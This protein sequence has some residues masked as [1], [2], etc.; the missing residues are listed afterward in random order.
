MNAPYDSAFLHPPLSFSKI[1]YPLSGIFD[2]SVGTSD[3]LTMNPVGMFSL[4]N[5][6]RKA[7][8]STKVFNVAKVFLSERAD[9]TVDTWQYVRN[10]DARIYGI[11]L[12]WSAH[13]A[14]AFELARRLK[15]ERPESVILFGGLTSTRYYDELLREHPYIDYVL[16]AEC[17]H[18]ITPFTEAVL[19][20]RDPAASTP[21]LG[22]RRDGRVQTTSMRPATARRGRLLRLP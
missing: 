4:A 16:L 18:A 19:A 15:A 11:G 20:R 7:G 3:M 8:H 2:S 10:I 22:F 21:N 12:H 1:K 14:G 5:V 13:A 9:R 17:E 6:L